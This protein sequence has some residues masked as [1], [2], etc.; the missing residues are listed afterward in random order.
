ML[1][2]YR[3]GKPAINN[4]IQ[5]SKPSRKIYFSIKELSKKSSTSSTGAKQ[6]KSKLKF[7]H[8][9]STTNHKESN[10]VVN[11]TII[12]STSKGLLSHLEAYKMNIGGE[13]LCQVH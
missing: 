1:L 7:E 9:L 11:G 13:V 10:H 2:K 8:F 12:V 6:K 4:I 5:I 3:E